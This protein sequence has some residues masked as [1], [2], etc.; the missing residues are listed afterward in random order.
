MVCKLKSIKSD[1]NILNLI[2]K[3]YLKDNFANK[4]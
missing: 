4:K 2:D 3:I 1:F